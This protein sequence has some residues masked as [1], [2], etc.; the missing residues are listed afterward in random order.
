MSWEVWGPP[1]VVVF[2]GLIA[3]LVVALRRAGPLFP[4]WGFVLVYSASVVLFFVCSR[5]RVPIL[6][7]LMAH[8]GLAVSWG[9]ARWNCRSGSS[10]DS[11]I[12]R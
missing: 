2:I 7:L 1:I 4:A 11:P 8:A 10:P 5:F 9:V 12:A 6:P 3:G